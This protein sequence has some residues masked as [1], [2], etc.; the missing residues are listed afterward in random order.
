MSDFPLTDAM[1]RL[2]AT[3]KVFERGQGYYRDGSVLSVIRR[4]S[5]LTAEVEGSEDE[6][7]LVSVILS[8]DGVEEADCTCP[9]GEEW[10][11]WCKHV[12]AALLCFREQPDRTEERPPLKARLENLSRE[13][14]Q[15]LLLALTV[16][17]PALLLALEER[18][19]GLEE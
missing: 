16:H 19:A 13:Q 14:L 8:A 17:D 12:V 11:G 9:Y 2:H 1:I 5:A 3:P 4:G 7:Y 10:D 18:L 6:P 15:G